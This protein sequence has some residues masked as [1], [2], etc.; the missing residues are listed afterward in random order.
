MSS[1]DHLLVIFG[2]VLPSLTV[3]GIWAY[4]DGIR[5]ARLNRSGASRAMVTDEVRIFRVDPVSLSS[6]IVRES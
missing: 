2:I 3:A 6:H 5:L 1:P 4:A